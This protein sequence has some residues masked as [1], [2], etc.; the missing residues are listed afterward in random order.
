MRTSEN[1]I[2]G[3]KVGKAH[4]NVICMYKGDV[5]KIQKLD[6]TN[7]RFEPFLELLEKPD[8]FKVVYKREESKEKEMSEVE[9]DFSQNP[10]RQTGM[11]EKKEVVPEKGKLEATFGVPPFSILNTNQGYWKDR[12][13]EWNS[14]GIESVD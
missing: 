10:E 5:S 1:F 6:I 3:R 12:K 11:E 8:N 14:I 13:K 2:N 7:N 4:Q 9:N